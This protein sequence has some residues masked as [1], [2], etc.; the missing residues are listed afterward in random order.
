MIAAYAVIIGGGLLIT[1]RL[2]LLAL[3]ATFWVTLAVGIGVLAGSGHCMT[4]ELGVRARLRLRLLAGD[5]HL[6]RGPDLP[7]LHDHRPED[8]AGRAGRAG[9][10]RRPGRASRAPSSWRRRPTSSAPRSALLAG[11]VVV[12][13]ARPLLDRLLPEPRSAADDLGRFA[14]RLAR[15][16]RCRRAGSSRGALRVGLIVAGRPRRSASASSRPGTPARGLVVPD[17]DEMLDRR[18]APGRSRPRSRRSPSRQD[19]LDW[20]TRSPGPGPCSADARREPG[21]REPG[22]APSA[23][24]RSSRPSTTATGWSRCRA[25]LEEA[26]ASRARRSSRPLPVRRGARRR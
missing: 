22:P 24:R 8:R 3:A 21:A 19:V 26:A 4:A 9:R 12:C 14:A 5:R 25:A 15:R 20:D 16:Q 11:L 6:A 18:P 17:T 23:T 7:V 1:R 10:L 13:A 2:H